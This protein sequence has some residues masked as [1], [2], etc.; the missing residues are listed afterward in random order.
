M[1]DRFNSSIR[2]VIAPQVADDDLA[3]ADA[4]TDADEHFEY[5]SGM[6]LKKELGSVR[7][8]SGVL[9]RIVLNAF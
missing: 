2:T 1:I 7:L 5:K 6:R 9:P 4:D 3:D 8:K